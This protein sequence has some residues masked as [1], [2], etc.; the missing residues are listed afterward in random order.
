MWSMST[1]RKAKVARWF[2]NHMST[3]PAAANCRESCQGGS[4]RECSR[5]LNVLK[6]KIASYH[7]LGTR[8]AMSLL[9]ISKTFAA[10]HH[11]S[12]VD[13]I[14][15]FSSNTVSSL[16]LLSTSADPTHLRVP[17]LLSHLT[18]QATCSK[19]FKGMSAT[20]M[21]ES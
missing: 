19:I 17:G 7:H 4:V 15:E 11:V 14:S 13:T 9:A 5:N 1:F 18:I 6:S 10:I 2:V 12:Y 16:S 20:C 8:F 21:Q 3:E